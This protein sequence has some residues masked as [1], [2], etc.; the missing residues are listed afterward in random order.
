M[1]YIK[2]LNNKEV[3]MAV[4]LA[5]RLAVLKVCSSNLGDGMKKWTFLS[6]LF[7]SRKAGRL[8]T[9]KKLPQESVIYVV[10]QS[11]CSRSQEVRIMV[12]LISNTTQLNSSIEATQY[13][14][15]IILKEN[16]A[17]GPSC[18]KKVKV[19]CKLNCAHHQI[20]TCFRT[21]RESNLY[22]PPAFQTH[23]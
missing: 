12:H 7:S 9:G 10:P 20:N 6:S 21:S 15:W 13:H 8:L 11:T 16:K 4:L 2:F 23:I 22:F 18:K 17:L 1:E 19:R 5:S 14:C 3:D